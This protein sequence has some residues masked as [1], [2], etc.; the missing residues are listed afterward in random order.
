MMTTS[1]VEQ[2]CDQKQKYAD[3]RIYE[4][5]HRVLFPELSFPFS[6]WG[7]DQAPYPFLIELELPLL[8]SFLAMLVFH[9]HPVSYEPVPAPGDPTRS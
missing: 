5:P 6:P 8:V 1:H 3:G 4:P 7:F 2:R 9:L